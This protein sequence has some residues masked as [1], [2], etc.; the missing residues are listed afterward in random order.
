M[1]NHQG[2][3]DPFRLP[4][5]TQGNSSP[6]PPPPPQDHPTSGEPPADRPPPSVADQQRRP[7]RALLLGLLSL[8][9]A[10]IAPPVGALLGGWTVLQVLREGRDARRTGGD[11]R[12]RGI[13]LLGVLAG[14]LAVVVGTLATIALLTFRS[15]ISEF[16]ECRAGANTR[17]ASAGCQSDLEEAIFDRLGL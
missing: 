14:V 15:E 3:G 10:F 13:G 8:G 9:L 4:E 1:G 2:D 11:G 17:V 16:S 7:S 6:P 5:T 12:L